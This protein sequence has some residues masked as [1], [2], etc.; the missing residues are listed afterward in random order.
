MALA[1]ALAACGGGSSSSHLIPRH[2]GK[3]SATDTGPDKTPRQ[4]RHAQR[5]A[6]PKADPTS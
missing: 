2:T 3:A 5:A 6:S 4:H 1:A